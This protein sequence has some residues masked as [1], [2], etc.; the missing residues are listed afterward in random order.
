M[1]SAFESAF[2]TAIDIEKGYWIDPVAGPTK[3]GITQMTYPDLDIKNLSIAK[4]KDLYYNDWW[5]KYKFTRISGVAIKT[6]LFVAA[7]N[8]G[9]PMAFRCLQRALRACGQT[10]IEDGVLGAQTLQACNL[11]LNVALLAA[12]TESVAGHYRERAA[13]VSMQIKMALAT[14]EQ[15]PAPYPL[16]GLLRRAYGEVK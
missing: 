8:E 14:G 1:D 7:I 4:A 15:P 13:T 3:F 11:V 9:A 16:E 2:A 5:L 10:V 12:L 6:K